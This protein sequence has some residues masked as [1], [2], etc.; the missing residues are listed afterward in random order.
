LIE[1]STDKIVLIV[2]D[3]VPVRQM[4]AR[5]LT[6]E[7]FVVIEAGNG[8]E[9]LSLLRTGRRPDAIVLDLRMPVM[10]GWAFRLVQQAD[11][12]IAA[13]PVVVLSGADS[14]RFP[15]LAAVAALEKPVAIAQLTNC[16]HQVFADK[17]T[18]P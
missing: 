1:P 2:D 7:R 15:E 17:D 8:Q 10:D 13:I 9:A 6:F 11:P 14:H 4:L 3:D 12:A 18:A 16:L 5:A